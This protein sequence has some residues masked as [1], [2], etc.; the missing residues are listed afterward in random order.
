MLEPVP[1][2]VAVIVT[3]LPLDFTEYP[4]CVKLLATQL[5]KLEELRG[6]EVLVAAIVPAV[7]LIVTPNPL[8][9][10]ALVLVNEKLTEAAEPLVALVLPEAAVA[11]LPAV[12]VAV[13]MIVLAAGDDIV[14]LKV[15]ELRS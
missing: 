4:D 12:V 1:T 2:A 11:F 10:A 3:V 13:P 6:P 5:A 9:L 15:R 7:P 8:R 14:E